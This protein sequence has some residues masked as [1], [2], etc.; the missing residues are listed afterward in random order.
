[1]ASFTD[2]EYHPYGNPLASGSPR[3]RFSG[4]KF[5]GLEGGKVNPFS[6]T[7]GET[8]GGNA[9]PSKFGPKLDPRGENVGGTSH[10]LNDAARKASTPSGG[11]K[12]GGGHAGSSPIVGDFPSKPEVAPTVPPGARQQGRQARSSKAGHR[13]GEATCTWTEIGEI[14][15]VGRGHRR[16]SQRAAGHRGSAVRRC[17]PPGRRVPALRVRSH[18]HPFNFKSAAGE[19]PPEL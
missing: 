17:P 15:D 18:R 1:M 6:L 3:P 2:G 12:L 4:S 14:R 13:P 19:F 9:N 8:L 7:G 5:G 11:L 16:A 10:I